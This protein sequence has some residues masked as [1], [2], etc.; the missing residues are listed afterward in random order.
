MSNEAGGTEWIKRRIE[1]FWGARDRPQRG[2]KPR[3]TLDQIAWKAIEIA[4]AEG[5]AAV[6]M[7]RLARE[8]DV[9]TMALYRYVA[10]KD[11]LVALM[12]DVTAAGALKPDMEHGSW[13]EQLAAWAYAALELY[14]RHPWSVSANI[15]GPP[16]GPNQLA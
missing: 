10:S 3:L 4:D 9:S 12:A 7:Q 8:L 2:P 11:D 6:T 1:M 15:E 13:R 16:E 14:H 5:L